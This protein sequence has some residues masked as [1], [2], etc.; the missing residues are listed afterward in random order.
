VEAKL[1]DRLGVK[2]AVEVVRA[3]ELDAWTEVGVAAKLKRFRDD[4]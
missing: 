4:R 1:K 2:I 3:G